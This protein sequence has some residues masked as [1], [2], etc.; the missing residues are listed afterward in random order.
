MLRPAPAEV[1]ECRR[2]SGL[3]WRWSRIEFKGIS[4]RSAAGATVMCALIPTWPC[5]C[6]PTPR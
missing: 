1:N 2:R 6:Y 3:A 5:V 4:A